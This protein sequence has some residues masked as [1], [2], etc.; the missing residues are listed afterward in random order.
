M[1]GAHRCH[2][3]TIAE[4]GAGKKAD[5]RQ[6]AVNRRCQRDGIRTG[7]AESSQSSL[8]GLVVCKRAGWAECGSGGEGRETQCGRSGGMAGFTTCHSSSSFELRRGSLD[9][10]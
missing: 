3:Y 4:H 8:H 2:I 6:Q 7:A 5:L 1:P 10:Q 9:S